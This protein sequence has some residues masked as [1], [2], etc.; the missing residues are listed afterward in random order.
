MRRLG[1]QYLWID[2]LC[3]I[4]DDVRDW[5]EQAAEMTKIYRCS[6]VNVSASCSHGCDQGLYSQFPDNGISIGRYIHPTNNGNHGMIFFGNEMGYFEMGEHF[7]SSRGWSFQEHLVSRATV[8]F[9]EQGVEWECASRA[10]SEVEETFPDS[11]KGPWVTFERG[12][13][14]LIGE[15]RNPLDAC[16]MA[17]WYYYYWNEWVCEYTERDL[18]K[19][20]DKL[21]AMAGIAK[22]MAAHLGDE[23]KAGLWTG[24]LPYGL[25]WQRNEIRVGSSLV[26]HDE[27]AP[28]WSWASVSGDIIYPN[29]KICE[30]SS[31]LDLIIHKIDLVE[32]NPGTFGTATG[33]ILAEG[34]L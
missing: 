14:A 33:F 10:M 28:S 27:A 18:T 6:T 20:Q 19:S 13:E 22:T 12:K 3:I 25:L 31:K 17:L 8:H 21:P 11:S 34:M 1:F 24:N 15:D 29:W 5:S 2:A 23:Y 4:Q 26:R 7:L 9:T 30:P 32:Q 16:S